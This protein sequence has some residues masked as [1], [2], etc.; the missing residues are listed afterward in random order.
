[1]AISFP[2]DLLSTFP[3]WATEFELKYRQEQSRSANGKTVVKDFGAPLWVGRWQSR[4][5]RPN[6]LD[7]WRARLD[8]LED[9]LQTFSAWSPSRTFPIA[10]PNGSWPTGG[11]FSGVGQV[12]SFTAKTIALKG[13]PAGFVLSVGD[14]IQIG[15]ADLHRVLEQ[16]TAGAGGA[17]PAFEVRTYTWPT[18][19]VNQPVKLFKPSCLMAIVPGSV[20]STADLST[21]RGAVT[22]QGM[23]AR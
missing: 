10:Y 4:A 1:M 20:S 6:E 18:I 3:G 21:G 13:L 11:A 12:S 14:H 2:Y 9:G 22:F 16:A 23:E 15:S 19:A 17:T 8:V 7:A 5:M